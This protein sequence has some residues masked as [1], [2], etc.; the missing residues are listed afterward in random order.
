MSN[1]KNI[2]KMFQK[3]FDIEIMKQRILNKERKKGMN[4]KNIFKWSVAPICLGAIISGVL[5]FNNN[6]ELRSNIY[7]PNIEPKN[8]VSMYINDVSKMMVGSLKIDADIKV[9]DGVNVPYDESMNFIEK[10]SLPKDFKG[11][12]DLKKDILE[13]VYTNKDKTDNSY[14][15]L[16]NFIYTVYSNSD[17]RN[18]EIQFSKE[19]KPIRDYLFSEEGSKLSKINDLELRIYK[20]DKVYFTEFNYQGINFD[21][22]TTNINEQELTDLLLSI[23]K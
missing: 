9:V 16:N 7:E 2:K 22:E 4:F 6:K 19:N 8:N 21:I 10:L 17:E 18:I 13:V 23:I 1:N 20:Y 14:T 15:Y 12:N 11:E 5:L 3:E